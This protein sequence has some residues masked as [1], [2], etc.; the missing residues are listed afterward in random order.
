MLPQTQP[1]LPTEAPAALPAILPTRCATF[2][3]S[4]NHLLLDLLRGYFGDALRD[5]D[6]HRAPG[7]GLGQDPSTNFEKTHDSNLDQPIET[8]IRH[9]VQVRYPPDAIASWFNMACK[10]NVPDTAGNWKQYAVQVAPL[11]LRFY[12]RWVLDP[13]P[14]RL[15]VTYDDLVDRPADTLAA[16][17]RHITGQQP[18]HDRAAHACAGLEIARKNSF[19]TFRYYGQQFAWFLEGLFCTTPGVDIERARLDLSAVQTHAT[20]PAS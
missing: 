12:R 9:I 13:V 18:D 3:R 17:A 6:I 7:R 4:G 20:D 8:G 1:P 11:W 16:V 2:P 5:V 10:S 14:E 15:V 19:K